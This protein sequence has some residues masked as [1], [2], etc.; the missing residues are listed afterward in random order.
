MTTRSLDMAIV[1]GQQIANHS[2]G[3]LPKMTSTNEKI[4]KRF[5]RHRLA[6]VGLFILVLLYGS[7]LFA[8]MISPYGMD[9]VEISHSHFPPSQIQMTHEGS[10]KGPHINHVRKKLVIGD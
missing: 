8:D 2:T 4:L 10:F 5:L 6:L 1:D 9:S 3:Q 7:A